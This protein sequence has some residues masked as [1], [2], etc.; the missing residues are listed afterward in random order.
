M[1]R[2]PLAE[3]A[4]DQVID[5]R[6]LADEHPADFGFQVIETRPERRRLDFDRRCGRGHG[7]LGD[8]IAAKYRRT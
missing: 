3:E 2:V 1:Q 8:R 4:H 5:E 6:V 7:V